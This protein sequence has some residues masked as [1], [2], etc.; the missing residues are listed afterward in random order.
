MISR[1]YFAA[2]TEGPHISIAAEKLFS[3]GPFNI[4]NSHLYGWI[5][6]ILI[7]W[8][9]VSVAKKM[10]LKARGGVTQFVELGSQFIIGILESNL[11]NR[12]KAY[13]YA[14]LFA[15]IFFFILLN[16]WL[17]LAPGV[18][19]AFEINGV[20]AFRPFTADLNGTLAL[21]GVTIVIVQ[22]L[23][24]KESGGLNHLKHY[25]GGNFLNPINIFV[26]ILELFGELTRVISLA[27]RLFFNI[28]IGEILI[29]I[30]TFLGRAGSPV[31]TL[32]FITME[33]FV[34][35][36]QAYI[37]T[38]LAITYLGIATA[39][40]E[41]HDEHAPDDHPDQH[42]EGV[43][44]ALAKRVEDVAGAWVQ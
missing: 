12:A 32:P 14:P 42:G 17:G 28:L 34:G 40:S 18:G 26:G 19:S 24:I 22:Y 43:A 33:L 16:N 23:A 5:S 37:F 8:L 7:V 36:V 6:G 41:H 3:I 38:M 20:P 1:L 30:F 44:E 35:L 4:T 2:E 10:Q 31:T 39:H 21:A 15:S 13:K 27:L 25:F 11:G 29:S 9:L